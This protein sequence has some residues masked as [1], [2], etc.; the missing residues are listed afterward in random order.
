MSEPNAPHGVKILT[1]MGEMILR[2]HRLELLSKL[3]RAKAQ[4]DAMAQATKEAPRD[5]DIGNSERS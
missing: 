2:I 1:A 5:M 4:M 3:A